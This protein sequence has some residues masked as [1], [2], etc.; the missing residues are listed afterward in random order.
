MVTLRPAKRVAISPD[1]SSA[2][3][4]VTI[5]ISCEPIQGFINSC[6]RRR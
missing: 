5:L 2:L 6:V 1:R 4:P 3:E